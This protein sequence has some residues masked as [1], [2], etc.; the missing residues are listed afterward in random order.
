MD[1]SLELTQVYRQDEP[2]LCDL[3]QDVRNGCISVKFRNLIN[4]LSRDLKCDPLD[5]IRL[6]PLREDAKLANDECI[7]LIPG[8]KFVYRSQ[9]DGKV[10]V[11]ERRCSAPSVLVLKV[12]ARVVLLKNLDK[13]LVNGLRGTEIGISDGYPRVC[14]DNNRVDVVQM[15]QFLVQEGNVVIGTR[16][17]LPLDLCYGMT[18]HKSQSMSFPN[19]EV[20]LGKVFEEGQA[21]VALSRSETLSGLRIL[22]FRERAIIPNK[23]VQMFYK[24]LNS[25][26]DVEN[27]MLDVNKLPPKRREVTD[28]GELGLAKKIAVESPASKPNIPTLQEEF[29]N[30]QP[31]DFGYVLSAIKWIELHVVSQEMNLFFNFLGLQTAKNMEELNNHLISFM[32]WIIAYLPNTQPVKR[33]PIYQVL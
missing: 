7:E 17:Q 5:K 33:K 21:Y 9:D 29:S 27:S 31:L 18:I 12:G 24:T 4:C 14:F 25:F 19:V 32:M 28:M 22:N 13:S 11:F 15:T 2:E 30:L 6:F 3:L 1:F 10:S 8:E 16:K 26:E 20:D 23:H